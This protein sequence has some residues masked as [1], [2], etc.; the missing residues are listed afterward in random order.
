MGSEAFKKDIP[1]CEE[2]S[3]KWCVATLKNQVRMIKSVVII[4]VFIA[5]LCH[6][7]L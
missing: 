2:G 5:E 6:N 3:G 4:I 1:P 7:F